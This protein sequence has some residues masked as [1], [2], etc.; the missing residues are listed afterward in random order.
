MTL[1]I[2]LM[3][4]AGMLYGAATWRREQRHPEHGDLR[5]D[6]AVVV[7]TLLTI[8]VTVAAVASAVGFMIMETGAG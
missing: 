2:S 1:I 5:E 3:C 7:L 4:T 6:R 8:V